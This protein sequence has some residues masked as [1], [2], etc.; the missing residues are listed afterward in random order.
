MAA[1]KMVIPLTLVASIIVLS[2]QIGCSRGRT[3]A[4]SSD[5]PSP[6][7]AQKPFRVLPALSPCKNPPIVPQKNESGNYGEIDFEGRHK[8]ELLKDI[9]CDSKGMAFQEVRGQVYVGGNADFLITAGRVSKISQDAV[10]IDVNGSP[11][12]FRLTAQTEM[13]GPSKVNAGEMATVTSHSK[14]NTALSLRSGTMVWRIFGGNG[15]A[16]FD[17]EE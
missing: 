10:E 16:Y 5:S 3:G 6:A 12:S 1:I 4:S 15:P 9:V 7:A 13:C 11:A 14:D 2:T 8:V 17:C